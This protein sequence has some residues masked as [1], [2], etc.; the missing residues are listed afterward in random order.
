MLGLSC[1]CQVTG[2]IFTVFIDACL[3]K[4]V[5]I[6]GGEAGALCLPSGSSWCEGVGTMNLVHV[7]RLLR[8]CGDSFKRF[9]PAHLVDRCH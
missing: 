5:G 2:A 3:E 1:D 6:I 8:M 7:G 4:K 9:C